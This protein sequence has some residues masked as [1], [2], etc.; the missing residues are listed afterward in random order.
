M[1]WSSVRVRLTL[2]SVLVLAVVLGGFGLAMCYAIQ[3]NQSAAIDRDLQQ[4]AAQVSSWLQRLWR[5][6]P[7]EGPGRRG[8]RG[9]RDGRGRR[10]DAPPLDPNPN[11]VGARTRGFGSGGEWQYEFRRPLF[12]DPRGNPGPI[13][14]DDRPWD[15]EAFH[16]ALASGLR[17]STIELDGEAVRVVS[18]PVSYQGE[19]RGVVQVAHPMGEQQRLVESQLTTLLVL[20]PLA[21]VVATAGGLLLTSRALRPVRQVTRAAEQIGAEDLSRRLPV[22]GKDELAQLACTF[23]GMI[24][25]LE[26]AF[27]ERAEAYRKLE[28]AYEEQRR[29]TGDASH[30]LRTPLT[31]LKASTSL[32]LSG[33]PRVESY[34]QAL[35]VAD[36]AADVMGRIVQDLLLLARSDG[37]QLTPRLAPVP[38][39]PMLREAVTRL[40]GQPGAPVRL[41]APE[42]ELQVRGDAEYL[43]R[44]FVNLLENALRHT[45]SDG[46]VVVFARADGEAVRIAV[47]DSGEGIP[48]EHLP[49]V[50]DRFYRVDAARTRGSGGTGLGLAICQSIVQA[51]HGS[52]RIESEVGLG[53]TVEVTLPRAAPDPAPSAGEPAMT[54]AGASAAPPHG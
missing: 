34:R 21:L 47:A 45:P 48:P 44:L 13:F 30:E 18:L 4:R 25:R 23:N 54:G 39:E 36:Q 43:T 31:R 28:G 2:W 27:A 29:F 22:S 16:A 24:A 41:E 10:P 37:G 46:E 17:F 38:V 35:V 8:G 15:R 33:P 6:P 19:I 7:P 14:P 20:V 50:C 12:F 49:H 26:R 52:L 5:N 3:A 40:S 1:S 51:H 9:R 11:R 42:E 32:A 53:T